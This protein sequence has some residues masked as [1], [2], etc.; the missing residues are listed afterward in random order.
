MVSNKPSYEQWYAEWLTEIEDSNP[1]TLDKGRRFA[2]KLVTQWLG[3]TTD[4][5]DF[6]ICDGAGDGGIDIAYLR[7]ADSD[8][9]KQENESLEGDIWY[10]VQSK[11]GTSFGGT[12]TILTEGNKVISTLLGQNEHLSE[13]SKLLLQKLDNFRGQASELDRI[14]LVFATPT[15][16]S[17]QDR[18]ALESIK[19]LGREQV[20]PGFDVEEISLTTI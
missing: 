14:V 19:I 9:D 20:M 10:L 8:P 18:Q 16:I 3:V 13:D 1:S 4:D 2:A 5:D 11:Y 7:R 17:S 12:E 6:V 15:P